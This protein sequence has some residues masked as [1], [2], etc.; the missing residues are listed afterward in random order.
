[1]LRKLR[2]ALLLYVLAFVGVGTLIESREA[3]NWDFPLRVVVY[4]V[5]GDASATVAAHIGALASDEFDAIEVFLERE[6]QR[7]GLALQHPVDITL[8]AAPEITIPQPG[9]GSSGLKIMLWSLQMR[10]LTFRTNWSS[11]LPKPDITLFAVY[12]DTAERTV[13]DRSTALRKGLI[14]IANVYADAGQKGGN[15]IVAAHELLHT[16]GATDKYSLPGLQ[17]SYPDGY[18]DPHSEPLHPQRFAEIMAGRR[19]TSTTLAEM[20]DT[21][22]SVR[23]GAATAAEIGWSE[24]R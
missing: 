13:L 12:H 2:I 6:A 14:A 3:T 4:P 5:P 22:R 20:P 17:P 11:D 7:H 21:L 9:G 8:A 1:M 19:A 15:N 23:V 10:W 24:R 16:L 18:A